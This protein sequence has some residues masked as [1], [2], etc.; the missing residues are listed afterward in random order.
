MKQLRYD[1]MNHLRGLQN[2]EKMAN[3]F[4]KADG[5]CESENK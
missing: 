1:Q 3:Q 4:P 5:K 2:Q